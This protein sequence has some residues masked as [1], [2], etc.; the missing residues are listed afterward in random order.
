MELELVLPV[1][2][3]IQACTRDW[4]LTP[5]AGPWP[6]NMK[7]EPGVFPVLLKPSATGIIETPLSLFTYVILTAFKEAGTVRDTVPGILES[8]DISTPEQEKEIVPTILAQIKE[9][10]LAGFLSQKQMTGKK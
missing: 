10:L 2:I 8:V 7:Q 9:A 5:G 4:S 6:G 3:E 1:D